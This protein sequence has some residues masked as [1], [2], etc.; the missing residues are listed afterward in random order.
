MSEKIRLMSELYQQLR[1][2]DKNDHQNLIAEFK[3]N[4]PDFA[5]EDLTFD[6][7]VRKLHNFGHI[8]KL[9]A[10]LFN[11]LRKTDINSR[12]S[13]ITSFKERHPDFPSDSIETIIERLAM[14]EKVKLMSELFTILKDAVKQGV[15]VKAREEL[16]GK[17]RAEHQNFTAEDAKF[18][19]QQVDN[20]QQFQ[21]DINAGCQ[22]EYADFY[23][24]A[25]QNGAVQNGVA[26]FL[27]KTFS[28]GNNLIISPVFNKCMLTNCY[29]DS[30]WYAPQISSSTYQD[31]YNEPSFTATNAWL[32]SSSFIN[33]RIT[34]A[35]VR[36]YI[37]GL[38]ASINGAYIF[39]NVGTIN[40]AVI[41]SSR[42]D[43]TFNYTLG[44]ISMRL[45][46]MDIG[47]A[48]LGWQHDVYFSIEAA[49]KAL[50]IATVD[51]NGCQLVSTSGMPHTTIT[52]TFINGGQTQS[53]LLDGATLS[54]ITDEYGSVPGLAIGVARTK[55]QISTETISYSPLGE[56]TITT[57]N[58]PEKNNNGLVVNGTTVKLKPGADNTFCL[59]KNGTISSVSGFDDK[60]LWTDNGIDAICTLVDPTCG[61]VVSLTA[62]QQS[63][64]DRSCPKSP[65]PTTPSR[66]EYPGVAIVTA[67]LGTVAL[68][69]GVFTAL[70]ACSL[71]ARRMSEESKPLTADQIESAKTPSGPRKPGR[72]Q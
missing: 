29:L 42:I 40:G 37:L 50:L 43:V 63:L 16:I 68:V 60:Y 23:E 57:T 53:H 20:D 69:G 31:N 30:N 55:Y 3:Q 22:E 26:I 47:D 17:Y 34:F 28:N 5:K 41:D 46:N 38:E 33:S 35:G 13:V 11:Q 56:G 18:V 24:I 62:A 67:A 39:D 61:D 19:N 21:D 36:S 48:N 58:N 14:S 27:G 32:S 12:E 9:E 15:T 1:D 66:F 64:A 59:I 2:A 4:N 72:S 6:V 65:I 49:V 52:D 54:A 45:S 71:F 7:L 25:A 10:N 44:N 51:F 70:K 8:A